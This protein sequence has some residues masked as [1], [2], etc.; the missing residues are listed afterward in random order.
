MLGL[1]KNHYQIVSSKTL[2]EPKTSGQTKDIVKAWVRKNIYMVNNINYTPIYFTNCCKYQ[3]KLL[4]MS[5]TEHAVSEG[6]FQNF[7]RGD[8]KVFIKLE[9]F[10]TRLII[11]TKYE[12]I[13]ST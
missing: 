8:A 1:K 10:P 5:H 7:Q 4:L 12:P 3:T 2:W 13:F 11:Q 9:S 6:C